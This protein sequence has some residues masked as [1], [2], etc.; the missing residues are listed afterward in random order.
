MRG[1]T[2]AAMKTTRLRLCSALAAFL[3][4]LGFHRAADSFDPVCAG[5]SA[6]A[7]VAL[8]AA[9]CTSPCAIA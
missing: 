4:T 1:S 3:L 2:L 7:D 5:Q 6:N 8:A 9:N